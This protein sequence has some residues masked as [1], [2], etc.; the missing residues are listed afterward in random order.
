M[1]D[2]RKLYWLDEGG[3]GVPRKVASMN[4]DGSEPTVLL[5]DGLGHVDKITC[6]N[7]N[8]A[9]Y[10]TEGYSQKVE[11]F[12]LRTGVRSDFVTGL[13]HPSGVA[14]YSSQVY[15]SDKDYQSVTA[16]NADGQQPR[17]LRRNM[18]NPEVLKVYTDRHNDGKFCCNFLSHC[19]EF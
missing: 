19:R 18:L 6:D 4:L 9:L 1:N 7:T 12:Y 17:V 2:G 13:S 11:R 15:Y 5:S 10:W 3:L 16:V 14:I 8:Q